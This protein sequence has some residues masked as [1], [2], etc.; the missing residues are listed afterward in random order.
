MVTNNSINLSSAGVVSYDGT[1]TF[2]GSP[3]T[4]NAMLYG[5]A[6]NSVVS[7]SVATNGQILIGATAASPALSTITAGTGISITNAANSITINSAGLTPITSYT[8]TLSSSGGGE[9]ISY[10]TQSAFYTVS[11]G[12]CYLTFLLA[13]TVTGIP[14]GAAQISIPLTCT[15]LACRGVCRLAIASVYTPVP[16]IL[17]AFNAS[18][19]NIT[20][21]TTG[22]NMALTTGLYS[23]SG[24]ISYFV[25]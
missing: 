7:T 16:G 9:S 21:P 13:A 25:G 19:C 10:V 6:S 18:V 11:N 4:T 8:P 22:L 17:I 14:S 23:I 24:T 3:I 12:V 15:R 2:T 1:G 5:G 20:D